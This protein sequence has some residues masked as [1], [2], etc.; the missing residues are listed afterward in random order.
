MRLI[1]KFKNTRKLILGG[2]TPLDNLAEGFLEA[3]HVIRGM[4]AIDAAPAVHGRW[5]IASDGDGVVCSICSE[6]F[7]TLINET[8]RFKFCPNCGAK[9][10]LEVER[11]RR[12]LLMPIHPEY[13][14]RIFAGTKQVEF[15]HRLAGK[16]VAKI[17]VY[18]TAPISAVVGEVQV[19]GTISAPPD[20]LW[21]QTKEVAGISEEKYR[22]YFE[23]CTL[24][25]AY[26]I[27]KATWYNQPRD[28]SEYGLSR[29]P[30]SFAYIKE[31]ERRF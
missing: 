23:G 4:P 12:A 2:E 25:H 22:R 16:A 3:D 9:M 27:G 20:E 13:V 7:C 14:Q 18:A 1:D 31:E 29:A 28:L 24:A 26:Q 11:P 6:D 8:E 15:R 30:Q 21:E 10:G 17:I 19:L 5:N